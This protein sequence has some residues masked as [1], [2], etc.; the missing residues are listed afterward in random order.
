MVESND[1][2]EGVVCADLRGELGLVAED[3]LVA[4][5]DV[6]QREFDRFRE[7]ALEVVVALAGEDG[8]VILREGAGGGLGH[9]AEGERAQVGQV[10]PVHAPLLAGDAREDVAHF[11]FR[12]DAHLDGVLEIGDAV[13][14]VVGGL[15][16]EGQRVARHGAVGA[17]QAASVASAKSSK[18]G[19]SPEKTLYLSF[20][21]AR[22]SAE[23]HG[24]LTIA[25]SVA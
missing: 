24:Y 15:G 23:C 18:M 20:N 16:E 12:E 17:A 4:H 14:D 1:A 25:P 22:G 7:V 6:E 3:V 21:D 11:L 9:R 10:A 13:A 2:T 8:V 5:L 19:F